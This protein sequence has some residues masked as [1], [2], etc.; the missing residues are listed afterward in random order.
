M[1]D[2]NNQITI[3]EIMDLLPHRYPMLLVDKIINFV[4]GESAIGL[5]NVTYNEPFFMG[6]FPQAP[7][8]PGVL[9]IEALAQTAGVVVMKHLGTDTDKK[10]VYF[11][12]I[13]GAK[14]RRPIIPGDTIEM[15][16]SKK[17][18]KGPV[19][20]FYG[21]ARVGGNVAATATY[22]AMIHELQGA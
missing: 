22:T 19:W 15:H 3:H 21:E 10:V 8:M 18:S 14:F 13:E 11:M 12:S 9:I 1:T 16:V 2:T 17:Q 5:K 4:P 20:K 6:H 7:V